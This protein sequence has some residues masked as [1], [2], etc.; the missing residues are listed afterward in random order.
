MF[1]IFAFVVFLLLG[2]FSASY[3]GLAKKAW[4]CVWTRVTFRPCDVSLQDE[5]RA[6]F[7]SK[8]IVKHPRS[9]RFFDRWAD[10]IAFIFVAASIWSLLVVVNSGLNYYIYDTCS[11]SDPESC[12]LSAGGCGV[13]AYQPGFFESVFAGNVLTWTKDEVVAYGEKLSRIPDRMKSWEPKDYVSATASYM[14][15]YDEQKPVALE[16]IDPG[17]H[18]CGQLFS[19]IEETSFADKY[20]LTYVVFPIPDPRTAGA[21]KFKNS[22]LFA[23]YLEATKKYPLSNAEMG[24]DWRLLSLI[25]TGKSAGGELNQ[26]LFNE[27]YSADEAEA[28]ITEWLKTF[29]YDMKTIGLIKE[30]AH[31]EAVAQSIAAQHDL[32]LN[33][34]RT[35]KIPTIMFDGRRYDKAV[36]AKTL[37][38]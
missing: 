9:A 30:Y 21:Y 20:N 24:A 10:T 23:R 17:C 31:G 29:G 32:V 8:L 36:D 27:K 4:G 12:T 19:T 38:K 34:I 22:Y 26:T 3:R 6:H 18:Y 25:F 33:K 37:L 7:M 14:K 1:C 5:I 28:T 2:I 13:G 15:K 35:V 16:I 11:P